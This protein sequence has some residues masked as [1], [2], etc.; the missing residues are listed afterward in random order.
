MAGQ[1][2]GVAAMQPSQA[3]PSPGRVLMPRHQALIA[4][5]RAGSRQSGQGGFVTSEGAQ[6]AKLPP[7]SR[8]RGHTAELLVR[9]VTAVNTGSR[10]HANAV[11]TDPAAADLCRGGDGKEGGLGRQPIRWPHAPG[12]GGRRWPR[13]YWRTVCRNCCTRSDFG[14]VKN[15]SGGACSISLPF[16]RNTT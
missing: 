10:W 4:S 7:G 9:C 12:C 8:F 15:S 6:T 14:R 3:L 16:S 13:R 5:E 2:R 11:T 1:R